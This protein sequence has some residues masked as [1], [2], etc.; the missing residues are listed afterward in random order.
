M[1]QPG[2][3]HRQHSSFHYSKAKLLLPITEETTMN[4]PDRVRLERLWKTLDVSWLSS[5]DS[6]S[7][8]PNGGFSS[9]LE[10]QAENVR[11]ATDLY[12]KNI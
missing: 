4:A 7:S 2:Y 6:T 3:V 1:L 9:L 12:S 8:E 10:P 11:K 5:S